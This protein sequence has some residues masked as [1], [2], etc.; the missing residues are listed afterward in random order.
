MIERSAAV[1]DA[2]SW[3]LWPIVVR[4]ADHAWW[5]PS[6]N[7]QSRTA[8]ARYTGRRMTAAQDAY[9][10]TQL[11]AGRSSR[12]IGRELGVSHTTVLAHTNREVDGD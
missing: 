3:C 10:A 8:L 2:C 4:E 5:C 7:T 9:A 6:H 1:V 12:S 11:Q